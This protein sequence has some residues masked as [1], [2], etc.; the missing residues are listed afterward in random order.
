MGL[1][2]LLLPPAARWSAILPNAG[3]GAGGTLTPMPSIRSTYLLPYLTEHD[4]TICIKYLAKRSASGTP[5]TRHRFQILT[6]VKGAVPLSKREIENTIKQSEH[7]I[8]IRLTPMLS[9]PRH[10]VKERQMVVRTVKQAQI[11]RLGT[12]K[13]FREEYSSMRYFLTRTDKLNLS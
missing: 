8:R 9:L 2:S 10:P 3:T 4:G 5:M 6:T 11:E 13:K 1:M 12:Y 7:P